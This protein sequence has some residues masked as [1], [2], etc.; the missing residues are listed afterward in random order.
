[1]KILIEILSI[2]FVELDSKP[3]YVSISRGFGYLYF[4]LLLATITNSTCLFS[5]KPFITDD[6]IQHF[7]VKKSFSS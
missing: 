1:M 3:L 5:T 6:V 4:K 7:F 2:F